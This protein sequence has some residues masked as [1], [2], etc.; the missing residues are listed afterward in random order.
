MFI[1]AHRNLRWLAPIAFAAIL[2]GCASTDTAQKTPTPRQDFQTYRQLVVSAIGQVDAALRALDNLS[3]QANRD[4]PR[5]YEAFAKA[6]E[7]LDVDSIKVREH[8]QA[9]RARGDAYFEHWEEYLAGVNNEGVRQRAAEHREELKQSF[10]TVRATSQQ[11][12]EEFRPFLT[13]LQTLCAVLDEAPTLAHIDG[14]K[15][16]ILAADEKGKQVQQNLERILA[17]MNTMT[18]LLRGTDGSVKH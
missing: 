14:Q 9:M 8:T 17:E 3:A 7:R 12:R 10:E 4:P 11:V 16:L 6:V 1:R 15:S 18:A 5:A 13:E 2:P